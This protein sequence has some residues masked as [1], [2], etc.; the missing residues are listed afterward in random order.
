MSELF[1]ET[2]TPEESG[3]TGREL[4]PMFTQGGCPGPG[5]PKGRLNRTTIAMRT[6]IAAV[7]EDLQMSCRGEGEYPHFLAWA[8]KHPTEFYRLAAR[9][10]PVQLESSGQAIGVV[11]FRGVNDDPA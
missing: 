11:V 8:K 4:A 9:Q 6:A 1:E 3:T 10:I 7:F 2:G 5:R